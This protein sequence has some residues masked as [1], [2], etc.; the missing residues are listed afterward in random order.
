MLN[1]NKSKYLTSC[2]M[3]NSFTFIITRNFCIIVTITNSL[4]IVYHFRGSMSKSLKYS[5]QPSV[6]FS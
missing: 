2:Y 6:Y 5:L 1:F 3:S 4:S